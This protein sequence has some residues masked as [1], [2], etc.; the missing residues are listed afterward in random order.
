MARGVG[1][2][3]SSRPIALRPNM[4]QTGI[5]S[6]DNQPAFQ[7]ETAVLIQTAT[8][9]TVCCVSVDRDAENTSG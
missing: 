4:P 1:F 2:G 7:L 9:H 5:D 3:D 8:E 6:L